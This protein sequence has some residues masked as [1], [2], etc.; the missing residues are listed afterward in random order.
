MGIGTEVV[1]TVTEDTAAVAGTMTMAA[2]SGI[3]RAT[4]T[5]I[6]AANEGI[7]LLTTALVCWVGPLA[8]HNP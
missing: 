2:E 7:S 8:F 5:M 3:M 1:E 4:G 6:R